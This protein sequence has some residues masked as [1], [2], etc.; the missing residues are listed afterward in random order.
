SSMV[1]IRRCRLPSGLLA[2]TGL[3]GSLGWIVTRRLQRASANA[4]QQRAALAAA[5]QRLQQ[6]LN[7]NSAGIIIA[8]EA[9]RIVLANRAAGR[10]FG[11]DADAL[12]TLTVEALVPGDSRDQHPSLRQRYAAS[13]QPGKMGDKRWV[14]GVRQDGSPVW[15]EIALAPMLTATGALVIANIEDVTARRAAEDGHRREQE[16]FTQLTRATTD[17]VWEWD[18][19]DDS[20]W[21]SDTMQEVYGWRVDGMVTR[22]WMRERIHPDDRPRMASDLEAV[23]GGGHTKWSC[24]YRF[25]HADGSYRGVLLRAALIRNPDGSLQRLIGTMLDLSDRIAMERALRERTA[26]LERSN[27]ELERFAQIASHDLQE[28]LRTISSFVQL[29]DR[30]Y[31]DRLDEDG[32]RFIRYAVDGAQRQ[33]SLIEA[34]LAYSRIGRL[35]APPGEVVDLDQVLHRARADLGAALTDNDATL[36]ADPLPS[37]AGNESQLAQLL[38]NLI[39]NALKYRREEAPRIHVSAQPEGNDTWRLSV[40]DNG[41]GI[42]ARYFERIFAVFQRLHTREAYEGTGIGLA[43]CKRIAERH[44]GRIWLESEVGQGST[45]HVTLRKAERRRE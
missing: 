1:P 6:V 26:E 44:G 39:G 23:V 4:A 42:E 5:D 21:L 38:Q 13:S 40:T 31:G 24:E 36:S 2:L 15:V 20:V 30:R 34:L 43:I 37:V 29:L 19:S 25:R 10:I 18:T 7:I 12:R 22:G 28:P 41:I 27:N 14:C 32:R 8:D 9:G 11:Y 16:R 33:R 17:T 45:F 3:A 35:D